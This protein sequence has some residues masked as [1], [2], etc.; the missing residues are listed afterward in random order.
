MRSMHTTRTKKKQKE[1]QFGEVKKNVS[2]METEEAQMRTKLYN[3]K[4]KENSLSFVYELIIL[5][6]EIDLN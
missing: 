4:K 2:L 1:E 3:K 5:T 6:R